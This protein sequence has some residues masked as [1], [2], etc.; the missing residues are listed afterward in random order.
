MQQLFPRRAD[1]DKQQ[2]TRSTANGTTVASGAVLQLDGSGGDLSIGAEALTLNGSGIS[3]NGALR[4]IA[5]SN[6]WA[7]AITLGSASNIRRMLEHSL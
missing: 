3:S 1:R 5:G 6:S 2:R 7:G 4:N